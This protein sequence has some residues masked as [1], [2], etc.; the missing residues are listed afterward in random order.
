MPRAR[1]EAITKPSS[2]RSVAIWRVN[3]CPTAEP[4]R[5]PDDG[6]DGNIGEIE[7]AFELDQRRG[8]VDLGKRR[9]IAGLADRHQVSA[10]AFCCLEFRLGFRLGAETNVLRPAAASRQHGQRVDGGFGA[11]EFVDQRAEGGGPDISLLISRS[12]LTRC[13]RFRR[14]ALLCG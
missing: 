7:P 13:W 12:Q 11:A 4:L 5:A 9:R 3:F 1:P 14:G 6:D 8:R 2:A 10:Q